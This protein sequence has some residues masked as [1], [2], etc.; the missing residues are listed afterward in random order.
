MSNYLFDNAAEAAAGQRMVAL[1]ALHDV[2][3][4]AVIERLGIAPGWRCLEV[5]G[6]NG[7]IGGWLAGRVGP[8]GHVLVTDIDPRF[9]VSDQTPANLEV[10]THDVTRDP[11]PDKAFNLVHARLVLSWLPGREAVLER[12]IATLKPG[13]WLVIEDY[14][15][16]L[17]A[18]AIA[19]ADAKAEA[20]FAAA[21][22]M[23]ALMLR[24]QVD[25]GWAR[26]LARHLRRFGLADVGL[27]GSFEE[28]SG[29]SAYAGLYRANFL[30]VRAAA[31]AA[32]LADD[33]TF[34]RALELLEDPELS[35][36]SPVMVSAWGRRP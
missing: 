17:L 25:T 8:G 33:A 12:L 19:G 20:Y 26:G 5:G 14:D 31:V 35:V 21:R 30:Q 7:S 29:G 32:G 18:P 23:A 10:R 34:G 15:A 6:G 2:A 16:Q 24:Q 11:L 9:M 27:R 36:L 28:W 13:G 4:K 22:A 3:T 1:S